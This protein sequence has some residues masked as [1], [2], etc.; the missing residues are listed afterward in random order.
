MRESAAVGLPGVGEV[1]EPGL[2]TA[3]GLL[4]GVGSAC[5]AGMLTNR[6][7]AANNKIKRFFIK[8]V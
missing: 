7:N 4:E 2:A 8:Q 5:A 3:P 1:E 6:N